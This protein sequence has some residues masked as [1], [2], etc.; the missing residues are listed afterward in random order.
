MRT[1]REE[2]REIK[3]KRFL[4]I[5]KLDMASSNNPNYGSINSQ[6]PST[7]FSP[8][9]LLTKRVSLRETIHSNLLTIKKNSQKL[10]KIQKVVKAQNIC[11]E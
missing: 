11:Y 10:E 9:E 7:S 8:T 6:A 4:F 3:E 5:T 1:K 2:E